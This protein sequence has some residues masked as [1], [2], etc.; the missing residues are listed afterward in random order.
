MKVFG[1]WVL[2]SVCLDRGEIVLRKRAL[3][4]IVTLKEQ[5]ILGQLSAISRLER[6]NL[7]K[8]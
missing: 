7:D 3:Q 4:E 8:F 2:S 1:L 5:Q 6:E